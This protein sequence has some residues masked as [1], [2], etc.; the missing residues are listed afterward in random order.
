M[1]QSAVHLAMPVQVEQQDRTLRFHLSK[2]MDATPKRPA[3]P[4]L[5]PRPTQLT[6]SMIRNLG[7]QSHPFQTHLLLLILGKVM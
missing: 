2:M 5:L 4:A 1:L 3:Q 6:P 7:P